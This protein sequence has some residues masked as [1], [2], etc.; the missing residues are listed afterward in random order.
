MP[1][2]VRACT[3]FAGLLLA[4]VCS[5]TVLWGQEAKD[6]WGIWFMYFGQNRIA[7]KSSIHTEL[8][9]RYWK[10]GQN[11][12]QFLLRLG[13][14]YD[15]NS[16]NMAS[17]GYAFIDTSPFLEG[18]GEG[19][20]TENRLWQQYVQRAKLGR[21]DFKHRFRFEQRWINGDDGT[22]FSLRYR[23]RILVNVTL[24]RPS[25]SRFFLSFYDE[26]LLELE[27]DPFDQNRLYG[28]LAYKFNDHSNLQIG[29]LLNS[30][31]M[32][33]NRNRLQVAFFFNP[34][35]RKKQASTEEQRNE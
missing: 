34:D 3:A 20:T 27:S 19:E 22:E 29:Y 14:N 21:I 16:D 18:D 31:G 15:I 26:I 12:N 23:Y 25:T 9:L 10:L 6:E 17:G 30:F 8:Q 32:G 1:T 7:D 4:L 28:A 24:G 33:D 2:L 5:P 13:Y 11:Y 35:L